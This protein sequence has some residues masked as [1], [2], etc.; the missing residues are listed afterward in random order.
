MQN[1]NKAKILVV[2]DD[3]RNLVIMKH[4]LEDSFEIKTAESGEKAWEIMS[5]FIPDIIL[6]DIMM[7]GMDGYELSKKVKEDNQLRFVK[8]ILVSGKSSLDSRLKG[9]EYGADDYITKPF[10]TDELLAKIR[11]YLNLKHFEEVDSLKNSFLSLISHETKTPISQILGYSE[12]LLGTR[13]SDEQRAWIQVIVQSAHLLLENSDK[14]L[15]LSQLKKGMPINKEPYPIKDILTSLIDNNDPRASNQKISFKLI[16][17]GNFEIHTDTQ[18]FKKSLQFIVDN[19]LRFSPEGSII[20]INYKL[21]N[22][23]CQIN[24]SD[25]GSG[26]TDNPV[27]KVFKE[28]AVN[29]ILHHTEGLR[30]SLAISKAIVEA[31]GGTLTAKNNPDSGA[32]FQF[33]IPLL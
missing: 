19:A 18:L 17:T 12:L 11:V 22:E 5:G 9:Y 27:S 4:M 10:E 20:S 30:I 13:L 1:S 26:I 29:N 16:G 31:H 6:L 3:K 33:Q 15:L 21:K 32:T 8:I 25:Q 23:L 14:I 24:I 28:F 2:D 7:P